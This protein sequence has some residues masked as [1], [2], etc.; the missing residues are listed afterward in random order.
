MQHTL[1]VHTFHTLSPAAPLL[2]SP[3]FW[4]RCPKKTPLVVLKAVC[5]YSRTMIYFLKEKKKE[6]TRN[7]YQQSMQYK[8]PFVMDDYF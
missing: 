3:P 6:K 5:S 8:E 4:T 2:P 1:R 7:K